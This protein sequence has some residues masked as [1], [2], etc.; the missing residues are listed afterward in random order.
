[1]GVAYIGDREVGKTTLAME[2][3]KPDF[4]YVQA[5]LT[6]FENVYA[7]L[8]DGVINRFKPTD[9]PQSIEEADNFYR[10]RDLQ[11]KVNLPAGSKKIPVNWIDTPGEI[12]QPSRQ[13][14]DPQQLYSVLPHIRQ[15]KGILLVLQPYR[16]MV[17]QEFRDTSFFPTQ[18]QWSNRLQWWANFFREQCSQVRRVTLCLSKADLFCDIE[19]ESRELEYH[20]SRSRRNW[21]ERN[22]YTINRFFSPAVSQLETISRSTSGLPVQCFITS[23]YN[24]KLLELPWIYLA[25]YLDIDRSY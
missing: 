23:I 8:F 16:E 9:V 17:R 6:S 19:Q 25:S 3:F 20:P 11:V 18:Q 7:S 24:R 12:W 22:D 15:S 21:F 4:L 10:G 13:M 1:M 2:L 5:Q 14:L